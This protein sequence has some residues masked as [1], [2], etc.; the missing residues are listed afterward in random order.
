MKKQADEDKIQAFTSE[1]CSYIK[2]VEV[3]DDIVQELRGHLEDAIE[4]YQAR[5]VSYSDA[6]VLALKDMGSP[7]SIGRALHR[8]LRPKTDWVFVAMI[9]LYLAVS[10]LTMFSIDGSRTLNT[11]QPY[12]G[13]FERKLLW[14]IIGLSASIGVALFD[15]RRIRPYSKHLLWAIGILMIYTIVFGANVMG[16]RYFSSWLPID[17]IGL[18]PF[19]LLIALTGFI[20]N[21]DLS[22]RND[23]LKFVAMV[24]I[25]TWIFFREHTASSA[26]EYGLGVLVLMLITPSVRKQKIVVMGGIVFFLAIWFIPLT[27]GLGSHRLQAFL[28]PKLYAQ[29]FAYQYVQG[30]KALSAAGLW[31]H[32]IHASLPMLPGIED[33]MI[34]NYLV[35]VFGWIGGTVIVALM[36]ALITRLIWMS[37][38]TPDMYGQQ[39]VFSIGMMLAIQFVYPILM[40]LGILPLAGMGFPMFTTD[41]AVTIMEFISVGVILSV[42]RRRNLIRTN[43]VIQETIPNL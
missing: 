25:P 3:H 11:V 41:G 43:N 18:A 7:A 37:R 8:V 17:V 27:S 33:N 24:L 4:L 39:L 42:Y 38:K 19:P 16:R 6:V 34:F 30:R 12:H 15:Y 29:T 32:G 9:A 35:Y 10:L 23:F 36:V 21:L 28:R 5:G 22:K 1:V 14:T 40:A 31:G 13:I 2:C 20:G 26:I